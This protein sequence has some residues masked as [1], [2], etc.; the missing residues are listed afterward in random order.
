MI[1][2]ENLRAANAPFMAEFQG[3][4][5]RVVESGWYILGDEVTAFEQE[6]ASYIGVSHCVGVGN[7]LD[8]LTLS[9]RALELPAGAEV[10]VPSNTYIATILAVLQAGLKP[11][12]VEPDPATYNI[13][14]ELLRAALTAQTRVVCVTHL[15]GKPCRMDT[16]PEARLMIRLGMKKG[17]VRRGPR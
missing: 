2:Y 8:A 15:Y 17:L 4:L 6:F 11:V 14:P 13:D 3:A 1:E 10:L 9:L 5:Q 16:N 7:G 12:L